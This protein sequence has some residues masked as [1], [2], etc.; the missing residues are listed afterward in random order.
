[1]TAKTTTATRA[2]AR[3]R[4]QATGE[5][6]TYQQLREHLGYLKLADAADALPRVLDT[7]RADQLSVSAALEQLLRV[8]VDAIEARR[9]GARMRS[10]CLPAPFTLTDFDFAA[11]PGVDAKLIGDLATL[12]FLDDASNVLFIGP[13]G[14]GKTML[15]IALARAAINAG[16]R[17]LFTTAA[18]LA[19]RCHKA[20]I[21]GRWNTCMR[22]FAA[23]RLLIIDELG[24][25]PL[26]AGGA[27]ALFQVINHRYLKASTILTT[28]VGVG[29]WASTFG[30]AT[31]AAAMLDRLL[32]RATVVSIDGPS[33]RLRHHQR[34]ADTIRAASGHRP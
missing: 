25:L 27:A 22:F 16:V 8:E 14:V 7:A 32:H 17:V 31:V 1:M 18:D 5:A 28:N 29:D 9:A 11:Q 26:P 10:S 20:A 12:R 23:P 3:T 6:L 33:Y 21:E 2:A 15:A 24:Y 30:D 4:E 19:A 13:P 34:H